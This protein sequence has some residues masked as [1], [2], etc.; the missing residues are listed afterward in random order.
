[1]AKYVFGE[2][3]L[4]SCTVLGNLWAKKRKVGSE[5]AKCIK[6]LD[7]GDEPMPCTEGRQLPE[8]LI[9]VI[10]GELQ[11]MGADDDKRESVL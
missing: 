2:K 9:G 6:L 4:F 3:E 7:L 11:I 1:M 5:S 8:E 10:E